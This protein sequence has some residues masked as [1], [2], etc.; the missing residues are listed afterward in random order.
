MIGVHYVLLIGVHYVLYIVFQGS[1]KTLAFGIPLL[2]SVMQIKK[3]LLKEA[4]Q[5]REG[6]FSHLISASK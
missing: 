4:E 5:K 2:N 6:K 3:A 1:G